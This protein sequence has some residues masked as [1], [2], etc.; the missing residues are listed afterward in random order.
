MAWNEPGNK[1]NNDD[2][3]GGGRGSGGGRGNGD[4]GPPDLDEIVKNLTNKI[5]SLF[6]KKS[7]GSGSGGGG[8]SGPQRG[9]VS[10][11]LIAGLLVV[12]VLIWAAMGFYTVDES[13]RGVV[14]RFGKLQEQVVT[15][16]LR[17]NPPIIDTVQTI[18]ISRVNTRSYSNDMLTTDENIV[19]VS[20]AVQYVVQD[21]VKYSVQVR[22]PQRA[23]DH[24]AESAIRHVAGGTTMDRVLTQGRAVAAAEILE[25]LQD[26]MDNY[27]TGILITQVNVENA[28]PPTA[29]QAAFDDVIRAREDEQ[30]AQNQALAYAN[31]VVP[32]ARGEAQRIIEQ[33]NAYRDQVIA[34]ADGEAYRFEQ[35][36]GEYQQSPLVTRERLYIDAMQEMLLNSSKILI[37]VEGGNNLLYLPLDKIMEQ[38]TGVTAP[39]GRTLQLNPQQLRDLADQVSREMSVSDDRA[40]VPAAAGRGALR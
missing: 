15:P 25:R 38:S 20:I 14:F 39:A 23:L 37:D 11:G 4:Q 26:Y 34:R 8:G 21:P 27:D 36:L 12:I 1:G 9:A 29:V 17:W 30:R 40:R 13:E 3:W 5:N 7:S 32:E 35:L 22:D 16:G 31:R 6:G 33:A 18:N 24:A 2:P 28:Q 10:G 19:N